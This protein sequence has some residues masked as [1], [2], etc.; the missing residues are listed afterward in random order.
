MNFQFTLR[1]TILLMLLGRMSNGYSQGNDSDS[2]SP[3]PLNVLDVNPE[4]LN[5]NP[6]V[7]KIG[8]PAA[9]KEKEI[10]GEV[11]V[12]VL[13][14]PEGNYLTHKVVQ[15]PSPLLTETVETH[16]VELK[17]TPAILHGEPTKVWVTIPFRFRLESDGVPLKMDTLTTVFPGPDEFV[18]VEKPAIPINLTEFKLELGY[19]TEAKRLEVSGKVILKV[20][21][22]ER[23]N[24]VRHIVLKDPHAALTTAVESK[25]RQLRYAPAVHG[26]KAVPYWITLPFD[27]VMIK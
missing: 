4:P 15:D 18:I 21:V 23:G 16:I 14:D 2:D 9:A 26:S 17:C 12:Q 25:I 10:E 20:L 6:I 8:Y 27:F 19:P 1:C 3:N 5:L 7:R 24:Y 11:V 22:N 13:M